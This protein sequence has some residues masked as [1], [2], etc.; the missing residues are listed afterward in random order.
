MNGINMTGIFRNL[1]LSDRT[2]CKRCKPTANWLLLVIT[3][4][5][6]QFHRS[7]RRAWRRKREL[8]RSR[9]GV[10]KHLSHYCRLKSCRVQDLD[11]RQQPSQRV[12]PLDNCFGCCFGNWWKRRW[13]NRQ[14]NWWPWCEPGYHSKPPADASR[15][16]GG[17]CGRWSADCPSTFHRLRYPVDLSSWQKSFW[18]SSSWF[19]LSG[20]WSD[21]FSFHTYYSH[22]LLY[23]LLH[24]WYW[25][26]IP[27]TLKRAYR[28]T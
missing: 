5:G 14:R 17:H 7:I 19:V 18:S 3:L 2:K 25:R 1:N 26:L 10:L 28:K 13:W 12:F 24:A 22:G 11:S 21:F 9:S 16:W 20:D 23:K 27:V 4:Q 6:H 15:D 8:S